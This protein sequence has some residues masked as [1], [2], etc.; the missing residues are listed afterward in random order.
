MP[1]SGGPEI[2]FY[3]VANGS[4]IQDLGDEKITFKSKNVSTQSMNFRLEDETQALAANKNYQRKNRA[5]LT[6]KHRDGR[7]PSVWRT[8]SMRLACT[9]KT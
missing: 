5:V 7:Y 8:V 9:S 3:R 1:K 2:K 6:K 4:K